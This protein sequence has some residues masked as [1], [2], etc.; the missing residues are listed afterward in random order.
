MNNLQLG[1]NC[2]TRP[3]FVPFLLDKPDNNDYLTDEESDDAADFEV[4]V[5]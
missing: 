1:F 4:K 3:A 5:P 2:D